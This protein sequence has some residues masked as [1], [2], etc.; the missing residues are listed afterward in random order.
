[1]VATVVVLSLWIAAGA[2]AAASSSTAGASLSLEREMRQTTWQGP[3]FDLLIGLAIGASMAALFRA[4]Q[5][6]FGGRSSAA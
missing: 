4:Y 3:L 2:E 6:F 1:L 5:I